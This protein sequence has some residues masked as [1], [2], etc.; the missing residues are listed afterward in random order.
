MISRFART[1]EGFSTVT[2]LFLVIVILL[3]AGISM[4]VTN[5]FRVKKQMQMA[6]DATAM[7]AASNVSD[8]SLA[9]DRAMEVAHRNL[10]IEEHGDAIVEADIELGWYDTAT[11]DFT[12]V[13]ELADPADINAARVSSERVDLRDNAVDLY[14]LQLLGH[15]D[16]QVS[17]DAIAMAPTGAP[18]GGGTPVAAPCNN[19]MIMTKGFMET[20][21]GNEWLGAVCLHGE[22]GL[23]TGGDDWYGPG[24][25]LSAARIE[26]VTVNHVRNGSY[27]ANDPDLLKRAK[28]L[29]TPLLDAL[30]ARYD[31][32]F[33]ELRNYASGDIY[34]GSELP[35]EFQGKKVQWL[36]E[37]YTVLKA[38]GT[39]QPWENWGGI[40]EMNSD[41]IF[42]TKGSVSL[43][44]NVD[45]NDIAIIAASQITI[46]GGANL[47][48]ERSFFLAGSS[49]NASG[50][51]R[52]GDPDHYCDTG[53]FNTYIFSLNY[54]SLGG[55]TGLYGVVGA[56]AQFHPGGAMR[57]A[58][59]L[60]FEAQQNVSLGGNYRVT[61]CGAQL[62]SAYE[63]NTEPAPVAESGGS[64]YR[65]VLVR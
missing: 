59:G 40:F 33:A 18:T 17:A 48:F 37:S 24:N 20:G 7:A 52:W 53:T 63:I 45:A 42:V 19:A 58:G 31:A 26:N 30:P 39:M 64:G 27:G 6:V 4:D 51:V 21:G 12:V 50:S 35:P 23:R 13:S 61:G 44:G 16:W 3:G 15:S 56:G 47:A 11:G 34:M 8:R 38:P 1:E 55:A 29:E 9:M 25:E 57:S 46:G 54:L 32:I 2:S 65:T 10:P 60:Y 36:K 49:F 14:L 5:V 28:S 43:E 41:T 22:T 62:E